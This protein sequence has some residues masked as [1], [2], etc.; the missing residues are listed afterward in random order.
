MKQKFPKQTEMSHMQE[1][2]EKKLGTQKFLERK[3]TLNTLVV[4]DK[5][6]DHNFDLKMQF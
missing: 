4:H 6:S 1:F 2:K 3:N 5:C